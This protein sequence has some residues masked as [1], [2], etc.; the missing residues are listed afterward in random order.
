M[1]CLPEKYFITKEAGKDRDRYFPQRLIEQLKKTG[2]AEFNPLQGELTEAELCALAPDATVLLTHWG[3][4]QITERYLSVNPNLKLI[5]H[6]AGTVAHIA[7]GDTYAAGIPCISANSVMA[8]YV[9]EAVLGLMISSLRGFKENDLLLQNGVWSKGNPA[10]SLLDSTVGLIGLGTVGRNLLD[11][12]APF[13]TSV[14]VYDPYIPSDVL[15]AYP[16]ARTAS[17]S[18]A[19]GADV[20]SVHASK[21]PETYHMIDEN[22]FSQMKDGAVFINTSRG[23]LVDTEAAAKAIRQKNLRAAFD[24]YEQEGGPQET[25]AH[26]DSVLL[27]PHIAALPAGAKMT[28]KIIRDIE[29]FLAG[30]KP[31]FSVGF[32]QFNRMTR[33]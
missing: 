10:G 33:E 30:E 25:L 28:E 17:F 13:G 9:A 5:A 21:T 19:L 32:E 14:L 6:C 3:A 8:R 29:R 27:Q 12:L 1:S 18:E 20:V 22:A 11:L 31:H 2:T 26:I 16:F 4:P 7:S 23:S 24:V 15:D